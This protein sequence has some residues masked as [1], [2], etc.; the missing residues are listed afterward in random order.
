[1]P[2][3]WRQTRRL[4]ATPLPAGEGKRVVGHRSEGVID[5][6][7][8]LSGWQSSNE[9]LDTDRRVTSISEERARIH[10]AAV[11]SGQTY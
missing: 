3:P 6:K 4:T 10:V 11:A 9:Y 1:M 8:H 5:T 7:V 2:V